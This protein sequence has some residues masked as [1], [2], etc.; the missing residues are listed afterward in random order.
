MSKTI[1][2]LKYADIDFHKNESF[3]FS[4]LTKNS[5]DSIYQSVEDIYSNMLSETI[6][7]SILARLEDDP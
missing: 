2:F 5:V 1:H 4:Q 6:R 7:M 3:H